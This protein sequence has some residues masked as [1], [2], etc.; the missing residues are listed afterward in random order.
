MPVRRQRD[1][2]PVVCDS[3][4]SNA[5]YSAKGAASRGSKKHQ[6]LARFAV[7]ASKFDRVL[8]SRFATDHQ[9]K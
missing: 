2:C 1:A 8:A 3:I 5:S 4:V 9:A 6:M 7:N